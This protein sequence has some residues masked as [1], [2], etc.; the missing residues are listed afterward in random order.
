MITKM[1]MVCAAAA[2]ALLPMTASAAVVN[3]A[4]GGTTV[5]DLNGD[6]YQYQETST[7]P[8]SLVFTLDAAR[9]LALQSRLNTLEFIGFFQNLVVTLTNT[10]AGSPFAAV[11]TGTI[12]S[13]G[14]PSSPAEIRSYALDTIFNGTNGMSQVLNVSWSAIGANV[15][16]GTPVAQ[17]NI[18]ATPS[19]VPVPAAG[20]LLLSGLGAFVAMRRRNK[21]TAA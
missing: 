20:L 13:A 7:G 15:G 2:L 1:K 3:L 11:L 8:G 4:N 10:A 9:V 18:Q 21:A 12:Q 17:I 16:A 6:S 19:A 5:L 14:N